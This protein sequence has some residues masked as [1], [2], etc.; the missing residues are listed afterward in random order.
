[1]KTTKQILAEYQEKK[2]SF[3]NSGTAIKGI[4]TPWTKYKTQR[5]TASDISVWLNKYKSQNYLIV[6]GELSNLT[7]F[8]IDTK[9]GADPTPFQNL[10]MYE[11]RTPSGGYH[12]YCQYEPLLKSTPGKDRTGLLKGVDIQSEGKLIFCQPSVFPNGAYKILNDVPVTPIPDELLAKVLDELSLEKEVEEIKP[13]KPQAY[14]FTGDAKPGDI[15]NALASWAD[16]LIPLGWNP[17][18]HLRQDGIQYWRRPGKTDG[19]S[20]STNWGN[21]DLL[22]PFTTSTVLDSNKGYTKFKALTFLQYNG[23]YRECS[24]ALVLGRINSKLTSKS[25]WQNN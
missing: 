7:V 12:F 6:C 14:H 13:Y 8:D 2:Y 4:V 3:F 18:G 20:A 5:P 22:I 25:I 1:M 21:H 9:N 24:K 17:V 19:V 10:G 15:Y 11:V 16:V 23:D